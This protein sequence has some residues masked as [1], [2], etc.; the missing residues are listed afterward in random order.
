LYAIAIRHLEKEWIMK[1]DAAWQIGE[2]LADPSDDT[3]CRRGS[4]V[5][6]EPRLMQLLICL[7]ERAPSVVSIEQLLD[8][9]WT[10]V[11]VGSASVYQSISQ[12]RKILG[13]T[14]S[15]PRYIQ[16]VARKGYRLIASVQHIQAV[17][18]A[19]A[20]DSINT[21]AT[22]ARSRWRWLVVVL[23]AQ[24]LWIAGCELDDG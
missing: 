2:W 10:G 20:S 24:Q 19:A 9:V 7:A 11:I 13:D 6:I 12:L 18:P 4:T 17:Q 14:D 22:H 23:G 1:K 5:K 21:L 8:T 16:T 3:L 15:A